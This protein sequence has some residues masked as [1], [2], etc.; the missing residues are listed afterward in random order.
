MKI[1]MKKIFK[2]RFYNKNFDGSNSFFINTP[3]QRWFMPKDICKL[4]KKGDTVE[5]IIRKVTK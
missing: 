5:L 4:L 2:I 3:S 1:I